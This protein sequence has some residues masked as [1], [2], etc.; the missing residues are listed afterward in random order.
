[1]SGTARHRLS[2]ILALTLLVVGCATP[3]LDAARVRRSG[4]PTRAEVANVPFHPQARLYCGPA[5]MAT[6]IGWSGLPVSQQEMAAQVYTPERKGSLR[7]DMLSAARRKGRLAVRIDSLPA[8]LREIS[9]GHPVLVFQNLGLRWYPR[10]HYAV[11]TGY[12]LEEDVL[13][14][15]SGVEARLRMDL[16]L[17][18]R[19]WARGDRWAIVVLP[20]GRLPE[21]ASEQDVLEAVVGL[22]RAERAVDAARAYA[23][24]TQRWPESLGARLGLGNALFAAGDFVGA[25]GAYRGALARHPEAADVWNNLAYALARQG[26]SQDA[27]GA[28]RRAVALGG[29]RLEAYHDTLHELAGEST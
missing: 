7:I 2:A 15:S 27:I 28:A 20:P 1:M 8:L 4:L 17:F 18:E 26:R 5:A 14:L 10:W 25:E 3:G 6:L 29:P 12:D 22:E 16:R 13:I 11:A 19:T 24:M 21:T 9:A 23:A